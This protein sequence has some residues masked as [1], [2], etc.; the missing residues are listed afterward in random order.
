[1]GG[2]MG[3]AALGPHFTY[4]ITFLPMNQILFFFK[5]KCLMQQL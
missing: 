4:F 3:Q 2:G 5:E 1:V